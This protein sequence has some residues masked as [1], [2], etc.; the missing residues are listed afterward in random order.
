[1]KDYKNIASD[2]ANIMQG[3][4]PDDD[5][6]LREWLKSSDSAGEVIENL[7]DGDYLEEKL[8]L[9]KSNNKQKQAEKLR[10]EL[11]KR[12]RIRVI[13]KLSYSFAAALIAVS[14]MLYYF[15]NTEKTEPQKNI[16]AVYYNDTDMSSPT[17]ILST[18]EQIKPATKEYKVE[19]TNTTP[20]N[21]DQ[22]LNKFIVPTKFTSKITLSDGTIVHMNANSELSYPTIF[23][24]NER[25]VELKGEAFFEVTPSSVPFVVV[26]SD[27][28][29]RVYGTKF[30]VRNYSSNIIST[31]LVE[32]SVGVSFKDKEEV[33]IKPN[34][35]I[36]VNRETGEAT[37]KVVDTEKYTAWMTGFNKYERDTLST[38]IEDISRWYGIEFTYSEDEFRDMTI[39]GAFSQELTLEEILETIETT[40]DVKFIKE[41]GR[42]HINK[43]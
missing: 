3:E 20:E 11:N 34:D 2:L 21:V 10:E 42:Y 19:T 24:K 7:T 30:N 5:Q 41:E 35:L 36:T 4:K 18:G 38:L 15:D 9:L 22:P 14:F 39:T 31:V 25:T 37:I 26:A 23:N 8:T 1:M 13:K 43:K 12:S 29:V 6:Q 28:R 33:R 32:G 16:V 27:V 40:I 17:V